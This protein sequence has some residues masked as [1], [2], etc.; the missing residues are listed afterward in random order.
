[1]PAFLV[2]H[3]PLIC[4]YLQRQVCLKCAA[5]KYQASSSHLSKTCNT[6]RT[7]SPGTYSYTEP[8]VSSDRVCS[9][10][11]AGTYQSQSGYVGRSC[12]ACSSTTYQNLV[13]QSSCKACTSGYYRSSATA[14]AGCQAGF[15]C[16]GCIRTAC[17]PGTF[18]DAILQ[19]T[20]KTW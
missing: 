8:T 5:G 16:S 1:M 13:G 9:S 7:C 12:T 19:S 4:S 14:Q 20:C 11:A 6:P 2:A 17:A 10:C 15:R 3:S 18:Q